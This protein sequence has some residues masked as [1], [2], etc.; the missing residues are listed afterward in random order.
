MFRMRSETYADV[1]EDLHALG[2]AELVG[3]L[4]AVVVVE[5]HTALLV[6]VCHDILVVE[7]VVDVEVEVEPVSIKFLS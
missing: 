1:E 6:G 3:I 5:V 7:D 2:V 4:A